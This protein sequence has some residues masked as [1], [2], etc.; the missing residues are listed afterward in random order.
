MSPPTRVVWIEIQKG[1]KAL[2]M[3]W[4]GLKW[5]LTSDYMMKSLKVTT[6]TGGVDWNLWLLGF[7]YWGCRSP[8]TRVVWI[9]IWYDRYQRSANCVTTHTGGVDWNWW[10]HNDNRRTVRSPPTRVVWIEII[11][12]KL[13]ESK[14]LVTTHTGGVDW[15]LAELAQ[16]EEAVRHHPHGWC[17]L[18]FGGDSKS[19]LQVCHHPHGWCGLKSSIWT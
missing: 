16:M 1:K 5:E 15:N 9:E 4:C 18:K 17:G 7:R 11:I 13:R 6:H 2:K 14:G 19:L 8:P 3:K 10:W 12:K